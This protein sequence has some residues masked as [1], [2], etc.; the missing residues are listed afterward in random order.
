MKLT[1]LPVI[2]IKSAAMTLSLKR[3]A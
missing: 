1:A 2:E 3:R